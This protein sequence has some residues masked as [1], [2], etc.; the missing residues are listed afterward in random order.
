VHSLWTLAHYDLDAGT[1]ADEMV[2]SDKT[3]SEMTE[4]TLAGD[5]PRCDSA[6]RHLGRFDSPDFM[7]RQCSKLAEV[8]NTGR[9]IVFD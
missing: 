8:V 2:R 7:V 3:Y 4:A 6:A 9:R 5:I 1:L